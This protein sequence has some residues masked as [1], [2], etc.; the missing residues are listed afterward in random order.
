[1]QLVFCFPRGNYMTQSPGHAA[2]PE[3][4]CRREERA[5]WVPWAGC[6]VAELEQR[7]RAWSPAGTIEQVVSATRGDLREKEAAVLCLWL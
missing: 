6:R 3:Q 7:R 2:E 5:A 4:L 1:M